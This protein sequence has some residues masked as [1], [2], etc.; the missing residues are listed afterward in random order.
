MSG[1]VGSSNR[2]CLL[3]FLQISWYQIKILSW[4]LT[5]SP[6]LISR[7]P[8]SLLLRSCFPFSLLHLLCSTQICIVFCIRMCQF[9]GLFISTS[10]NVFLSHCFFDLCTHNT[11]LTDVRLPTIYNLACVVSVTWAWPPF[12]LFSW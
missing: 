11:V 12:L 2:A 10:V 9:H 5:L 6:C 4:S 7:L 3:L 1:S 8:W